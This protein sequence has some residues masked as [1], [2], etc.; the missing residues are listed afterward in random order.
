MQTL[1][2]KFLT[3]DEKN[4][5]TETV[6][7]AELR[8]SGE[9]VPMIVS[10]SYEYPKARIIAALFFSFPSALLLCHL[11]ATIFWLDPDN[12]YFFFCLL[13]P[14]YIIFH[15]TVSHFPILTKPF[16]AKA[17]MDAEVREEATKSFFSERL[18]RTRDANGILLFISVFEN[19]VWILADYGIDDKIEQHTWQE[20]I[21]DLTTRISAD[22]RCDA[23][24]DCIDEIGTI[25]QTHF[26]YKKDDTDE[27]H[28]LIIR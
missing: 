4:R 25:L 18:Y 8:T 27:L 7:S 17:E 23:L 20:I 12:L 10:S 21:D 6:R 14:L 19:K 3:E 24:C 16:I 9:I 1:S 2:K 11:L 15:I 13:I 26:P 5:V 28:N 22:S